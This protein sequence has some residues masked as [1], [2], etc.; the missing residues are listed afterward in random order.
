MFKNITDQ[1]Q[2]DDQTA[3]LAQIGIKQAPDYH[4]RLDGYT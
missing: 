2:S 3:P 1:L 4:G